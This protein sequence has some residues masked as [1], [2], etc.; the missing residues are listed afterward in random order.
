MSSI[1][2]GPPSGGIGMADMMIFEVSL[3]MNIS[4]IIVSTV[5]QARGSDSPQRAW[6]KSA[7]MPAPP[8]PGCARS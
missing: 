2:S 6:G 4:S 3:L 1:V 5:K 7:P 8:P